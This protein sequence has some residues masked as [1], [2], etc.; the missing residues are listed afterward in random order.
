MFYNSSGAQ[1]MIPT[2]EGGGYS[3]KKRELGGDLIIV[4]SLCKGFGEEQ[5]STAVLV[6]EG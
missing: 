5:G 3:L 2:R 4:S 6:T 1:E